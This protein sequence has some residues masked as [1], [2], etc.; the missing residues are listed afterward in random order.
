MSA[1]QSVDLFDS[2]RHTDAG[3][4]LLDLFDRMMRQRDGEAVLTQWLCEDGYIVSYSTT[5][6][7]GGPHD[8]KYVAMLYR[9]IGKGARGG[10]K[11][12]QTWKQTY[13][14][15]YSKRRLARARAERLYWKHNPTRAARHGKS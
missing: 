9:P 14:M 15:G 5:R 8:G 7:R 13:I 12:A 1:E 3:R 10:R 4:N 11:T 2:L 6:A